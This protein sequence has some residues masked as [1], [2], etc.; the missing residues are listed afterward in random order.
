ML[1]VLLVDDEK[2]E[3]VLIRKGYNWEESGFNIVGEA[4]SGKD[5]LEYMAYHKVDIVVTD[6]NMPGMDGLQ[7]T[8]KLLQK[9]PK[10]RVVIVTGFR[11]FEYARRAVKL[12]VDEFLLK[13]IN[14]NE[15]SEIMAKIKEEIKK[16]NEEESKVAQLKE[17]VEK[18]YDVLRES[19]LLRLVENRI[20]EGDATKKLETYNCNALLEGCVCINIKIKDAQE[21]QNYKKVYECIQ[22]QNNNNTITFIHFMHNIVIFFVETDVNKCIE[23]AN[24]LHTKLNNMGIAATIGVSDE[25]KDFNGISAAYSQANK[26]IGVSVLLGRN[27]VVTF[28]EYQEIM[29]KSNS[30]KEINW[31]EF[32]DAIINCR[33]EEVLKYISDYMEII[34]AEK[35]PDEEYLKLMAMTIIM[36]ASS[37]LNKYGTNI[38][39]L[40]SEEE[41]FHN[42]REIRSMTGTSECVIKYIK[43]VCDYH[44]KKRS[45][46]RTNVIKDALDYVNRN[47]YNQDLSLKKVATDLYINDS[48]LS[49]EFKKTYGISFIEYISE[50]RIEASKKL[51][52]ETDLKVYEVAEKIGFKDSHYFCICFKKQTGKTIREYRN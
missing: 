28:S 1:N 44:E 5:A 2:L 33:R 45:G 23:Y 13:P 14:I 24:D 38:Y 3:R 6:I 41:V 19:F 46:K 47:L 7:F 42:V 51:L 18:N 48:Y 26:A 39:Q 15:L 35:I 16:V 21:N 40:A 43:Q 20:G 36:R 49:R 29:E 27:K 25:N 30:K 50:K 31:D 52:K 8:E 34:K 17:S 37:T 22:E 9:Y 11:E 10:C 32:S 4:A 12:G